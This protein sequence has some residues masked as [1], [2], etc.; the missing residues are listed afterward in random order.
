MHAAHSRG[1]ESAT[2]EAARLVVALEEM[3]GE[4]PTHELLRQASQ[5]VSSMESR[6]TSLSTPD[7]ATV[8]VDRHLVVPEDA[9]SVLRD[10]RAFL[11]SL[12]SDGRLDEIDGKRISVSIKEREQPYL[13][14]Y[15]T[16]K[17]NPLA[18]SLAQ[19]VRSEA[20]EPH[21]NSGYSVADECVLASS[22]VPVVSLAP[23]GGNEHGADEWV[24]KRSYLMMIKVL[25]SFIKSL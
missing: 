8:V 1:Q 5:Y 11:D 19:A 17:D 2:R 16:P 24:S 18:K 4:L 6:S 10:Y 13:M 3:N 23:I 20:G 25:R 22:G 15:H 9:E 21:Y 12:Y 14:P 7:E